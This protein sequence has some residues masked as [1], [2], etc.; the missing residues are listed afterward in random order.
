MKSIPPTSIP[1]KQTAGFALQYAAKILCRISER[2]VEK[3]VK[4]VKI[5]FRDENSILLSSEF[6]DTINTDRG[7]GDS[8]DEHI[9]WM[10]VF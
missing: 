7:V 4:T 6:Y 8:I 9:G 2:L 5:G 10:H 3:R 1:R